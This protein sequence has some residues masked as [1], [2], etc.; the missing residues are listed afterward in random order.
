M[1]N[2]FHHTGNAEPD[3]GATGL[4]CGGMEHVATGLATHSK[5]SRT[6]WSESVL[7][8][9]PPH[10]PRKQRARQSLGVH[11]DGAV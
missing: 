2:L 5:P 8:L 6:R 4:R 10:E 7:A 3:A 9:V 11:P 1:I